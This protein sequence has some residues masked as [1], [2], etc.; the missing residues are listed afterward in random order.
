MDIEAFAAVNR[1]TWERLRE[2]VNVRRL[3]GEESDELLSLYQRSS[4]HLST[5]RSLAPESQLS[6]ELSLLLA[7]AR[8]KF[9]GQRG[10]AVSEVSRFFALYLPA[11]LYRL[12]WA[13]LIIF[14]IFIGIALFYGLWFSTTPDAVRAVGTDAELRA[15]AEEKFVSYYSENPAGSFGTRVWVNNAWIA[16]QCIAL[17]ITGVFPIAVLIQN[18]ANLGIMGAIMF[19][20]DRGDTFFIYILPHGL[21]E[22]T[23]VMIAAAAG[24]GLFWAWVSPGNRPRLEALA[25]EGRALFTVVIG[26]ALLLLLCGVIEAYVTPSDLPVFV[27]IGIGVALWLGYWVYV[28]AVGGRAWRAGHRGDLG[29]FDRGATVLSA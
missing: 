24:L 18:A 19:A 4:A 13:T 14:A 25:A 12:R 11:A 29:S 27:R 21:M 22:M 16:A 8:G 28:F 10:N 26:L 1:P 2:L 15:L 23:C 6:A 7:S 17:G 5:I 20:H 3:S 9:T